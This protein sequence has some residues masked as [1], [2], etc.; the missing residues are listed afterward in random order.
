MFSNA[1]KFNQPLNFN[2]SNVTDMCYMF[3]YATN[4]NQPLN[5]DTSNVTDMSSILYMYNIA[6]ANFNQPIYFRSYIK[7]KY[8]FDKHKNIYVLTPQHYNKLLL[9]YILNQ[10]N[11]ELLY[12]F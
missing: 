2:T 8:L 5:F 11:S 9:F 3:Q 6:F 12:L 10:I 4:F 7:K 1:I